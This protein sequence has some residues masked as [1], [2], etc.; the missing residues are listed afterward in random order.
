[1]PASVTF[2]EAATMPTVFI[3]VDT[4]L[5]RLARISSGTRVLLH[6]AAG[7]VGLAAMQVIKGAGAV[8]LATAGNPT[9]R[10]L[11]R[12]LGASH[13]VSSR[14]MVYVEELAPQASV[15][16]YNAGHLPWVPL[17]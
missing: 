17:R 16:A 10:G 13:V 6:A 9:K 15:A 14:D 1:M 7:G 8:P 2:E 12:T 4:A 3:T 11:L 5:N